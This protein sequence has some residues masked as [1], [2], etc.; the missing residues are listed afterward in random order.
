MSE[1]KEIILST[2]ENFEKISIDAN[3]AKEAEFAMQSL[4]ANSFL[5]SVANSNKESLKSAITNLS[6]CNLSLNPVLKLAYLVPRNGKV[7]LDISY[8][9]LVKLATDSGSI[10]FVQAQIVREKDKFE[11][12]GFGAAPTHSYNPFATD[13]GEIIGAYSVAKLT[14]GDFLTDVMSIDSLLDIRDRTEA[15]KSF[16]AGKSKSCP[17]VSDLEEMLK[18]TVIR[19]ASKL[20][21]KTDKLN[22]AI[23]ILNEHDGIDFD[24]EKKTIDIT[25]PTL[26][27]FT[28]LV[29]NLKN[30]ADGERRLIK[31]IND[32]DK[33]NYTIVD[34]LTNQQVEYSL[35]FLK[36]FIKKD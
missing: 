33:C 13:R 10:E 23:S 22:N 29:E 8:I 28:E 16:K 12:N 5:M 6:A 32:K 35:N 1:L 21:P 18:K 14:T 19:R 11:M 25:P 3:F 24:K 26:E 34:E 36:Q 15:Y 31:H 9:G 7:C 4:S 20:W 17:W 27:R 30:I 2:K